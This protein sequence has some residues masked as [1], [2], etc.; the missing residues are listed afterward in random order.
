M[1]S[2]IFV[3][4]GESLFNYSLSRPISAEALTSAR[5][6]A[7]VN[8]VSFSGVLLFCVVMFWPSWSK[9]SVCLRVCV[10]VL[11]RV[12]EIIISARRPV[13]PHEIRISTQ[14]NFPPWYFPDS[15]P[16]PS[17]NPRTFAPRKIPFP[18]IT[19]ETPDIFPLETWT[20]NNAPKCQLII[21]A[22][23]LRVYYFF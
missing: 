9:A 22:H 10:C 2:K 18:A 8:V 16:H 23:G 21:T 15:P 14:D 5:S 12:V 1:S 20:P 4:C 17:E 3:V 7:I 6:F 19:P 13:I 11:T